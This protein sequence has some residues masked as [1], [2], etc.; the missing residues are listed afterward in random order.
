MQVELYVVF[1]REGGREVVNSCEGGG[2]GGG[3]GVRDECLII[4]G[5]D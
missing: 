4:G 1:F 3:E 2:G 5:D